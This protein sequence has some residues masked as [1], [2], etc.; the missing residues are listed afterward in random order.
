M[1]VQKTFM[2]VRL[3][4]LKCDWRYILTHSPFS[5]LDFRGGF[6]WLAYTDLH[7]EGSYVDSVSGL[8]PWWTNFSY[9][10]P[11]GNTEQ[12]CV[13][14]YDSGSWNDLPCAAVLNFICEKPSRKIDLVMDA[15]QLQ[16][17]YYVNVC[18][19]Q[20]TSHY[21][22]IELAACLLINITLIN[23]CPNKFQTVWEV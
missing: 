4:T 5:I 18:L 1:H 13:G 23:Y 21:K 16:F 14:R 17:L 9:Q 2:Q 15:K 11:S 3:K 8:Y 20:S 19:K 7:Q 12:N 22:H 10:Q 6:S